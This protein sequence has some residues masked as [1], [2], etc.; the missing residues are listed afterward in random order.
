MLKIYCNK[1]KHGKQDTSYNF[2]QKTN[3]IHIVLT[4]FIVYLHIYY[5]RH[6]CQFF[7]GEVD[8]AE[9]LCPKNCSPA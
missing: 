4:C 2:I 1:L 8:G 7:W 5:Q 3:N 6:T 9:H